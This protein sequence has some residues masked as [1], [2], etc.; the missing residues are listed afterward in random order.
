MVS[1]PTANV[2]RAPD[3]GGAASVPQPQAIAI[4]K[5]ADAINTDANIVMVFFG[6]HCEPRISRPT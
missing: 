4:A 2:A 3:D 1:L 5:A 6:L